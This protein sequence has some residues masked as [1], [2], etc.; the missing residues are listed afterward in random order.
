MRDVE[1]IKA[2]NKTKENAYVPYSK[3]NV[4]AALVT[5]SGNVYTGCNVE[6]ASFGATNSADRT[7]VFKA[8]SEEGKMEID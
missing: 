4:G 3:F 5:K 1:L 6:I 8:V 7:A 2:A